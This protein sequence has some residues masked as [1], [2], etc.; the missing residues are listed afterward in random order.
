MVIIVRTRGF[1][2][3]IRFSSVCVEADTLRRRSVP[4][5]CDLQ[6]GLSIGLGIGI[7]QRGSH[8][9]ALSFTGQNDT[10]LAMLESG[11]YEV[12]R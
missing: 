10:Y 9:V 7:S 2:R 8:G 1:L 12:R 6:L 11:I 5:P 4:L 3:Q